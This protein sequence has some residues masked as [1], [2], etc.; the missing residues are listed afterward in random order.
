MNLIEREASLTSRR[1][2][3]VAQSLASALAVLVLVGCTSPKYRAPVEDRP[4]VAGTA[5]AQP[6]PT[7]TAVDAKPLPGAENAGKAGHVTVKSGDTLIRIAIESGQNWRDIARWNSIENPDSL[8]VGQVLRV[9]PPASEGAAV[10]ARPVT[11]PRVEAR[12]L[13]PKPPASAAATGGAAT[14]TAGGPPVA[15][16]STSTPAAAGPATPVAKPPAGNETSLQ[17]GWPASGSIGSRFD[18]PRNKGISILGK[19]GDPIT[20]AAFGRVM[21]V[22]TLRGYG[23][24][25]IVQHNNGYLSVYGN[26]RTA[27]VAEKQAV[28]RGQRIAE[29]GNTEAERMQLH[30]EIRKDGEAVDPLKLLPSR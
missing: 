22:G 27:L 10:A 17:W 21:Y 6:A 18:E 3:F 28:T 30:F 14:P 4:R 24:I 11:T 25:V 26:I 7:A 29:M 20:A 2:A 1:T 19:E 9:I 5:P 13:E 15:V 23:N 12:P 16:A 8:Q